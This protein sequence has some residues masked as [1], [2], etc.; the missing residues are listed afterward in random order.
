V[1]DEL[2]VWENLTL[3]LPRNYR[4]DPQLPRDTQDSGFRH[5]DILGY[6]PLLRQ[7]KR[8]LQKLQADRLSG[9][10]R[11]QLALAMCLLRQPNWTEGSLTYW[12]V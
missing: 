1:F 6:F 4:L 9:G 12:I 2:S 11:H 5:N 10:Q 7:S 8:E 3:V